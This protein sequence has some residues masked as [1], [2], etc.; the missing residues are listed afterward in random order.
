M[1]DTLVVR[2]GDEGLC[3]CSCV[4]R[5][6]NGK[7][8]SALRC[9]EDDVIGAGARAVHRGSAD[10]HLMEQYHMGTC[11]EAELEELRARRATE[12]KEWRWNP[13]VKGSGVIGCIPQT[14]RC[15]MGCKDCF[16]QSGRSYL[17]PLDENLPHIP[18]EEMAEG[19]IV[20]MN[21]GN[22]SNVQRDLVEEVAQRFDD[23]F[24]NTSIPRDLGS[25]SGPVVLT[26]NPGD[27][28]DADFHRLD[29]PPPNLMFVR[30]RVN[31]W[32]LG[33]VVEPAIKHYTGLDVPVVLTFMAYYTETVPEEHKHKY[34]WK[35]RTTN[36]YWV[37]TKRWTDII[38]SMF[39][40]NILVY[41]CG[42]RGHACSR[43]GNCLREYHVAKERMR[44]AREAGKESD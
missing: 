28:T 1:D 40:D 5:C 24:F 9:T 10:W 19:R 25:F 29:D 17:E 41:S 42:L 12:P 16:F 33:A 44:L 7:T 32:N 20:R 34:E 39:Q 4:D 27:M 30:V 13:K 2:M 3:M 11:T 23:Y 21:D 35:M 8:G 31:A 38:E 26:V 6:P 43:C 15:P 22:D 14:G 37:M 36:S 18:T